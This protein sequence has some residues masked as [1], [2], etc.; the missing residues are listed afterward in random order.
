MIVSIINKKGGVGKTSFA[1]SIAK[2]LG[3]FLQSNDA[4]IIEQI[5]PNKAKVS[6]TLQLIDN[7]VFDF[8]GF[9][10]KDV[11]EICKASDFV[12]VPCTS[13]YNAILRT[14]ET[15]GEIKK[16]NLNII[17]LVT[18]YN[19]EADKNYILETLQ[20]NFTDIEYFFFKRSKILENAMRTG[21][22]FK[23]LTQ[24]NALSKMSYA[25]FFQEYER[26]LES[27]KAKE[28]K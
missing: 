13:L 24:E 20:S 18:D 7:C 1:F 26:L 19:S 17:V 22:S 5:Y 10:D 21:A 6:P 9:V 27:L 3:L 23:E 25:I 12:I 16:V 2:D 11:L 28:K 8:G 4:S 14:I 15:I